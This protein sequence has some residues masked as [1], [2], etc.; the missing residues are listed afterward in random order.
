M[1]QKKILLVDDS[2]TIRQAMSK[3]LMQDYDIAVANSGM[4]AIRSITLNMP[5]L[6]ILDYEMP[7][8]DGRQTLEMIRSEKDFAEIP[9]IFLTGRRDTNSILQVMSLNVSDYLLKDSKPTDIKKKI[10][11][12]FAKQAMNR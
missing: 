2:I 1:S 8:C 6:I 3:L 12:F 7:V 10:D 11:K 5:D 4:A 9:V